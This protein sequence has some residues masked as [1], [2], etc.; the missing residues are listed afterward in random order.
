V[1]G[2]DTDRPRLLTRAFWAMMALAALSFLAA[3]VVVVAIGPRHLAAKL[4]PP[5]RAA[6]LAGAARGAK[7][8]A[9]DPS[10]GPP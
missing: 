5:A 7:T 8:A 9:P 4:G 1:T 6:P 2:R 10:L 3:A